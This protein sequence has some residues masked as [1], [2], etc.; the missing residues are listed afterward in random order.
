M[1]CRA[2]LTLNG[3]PSSL[4]CPRSAR[5]CVKAWAHELSRVTDGAPTQGCVGA[6]SR[7]GSSRRIG[8]LLSCVASHSAGVRSREVR[9]SSSRSESTETYGCQH[10]LELGA[11]P[12]N[13]DGFVRFP[14]TN[15]V[16]SGGYVGVAE[17]RR[18]GSFATDH[19]H[20]RPDGHGDESVRDYPWIIGKSTRKSRPRPRRS[21]SG[22]RECD[23]PRS[24]RGAA[25]VGHTRELA[26][27]KRV[28]RRRPAS[29][30]VHR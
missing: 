3:G 5:L 15:D 1:R 26:L 11:R 9:G 8:R 4:A 25:S 16:P 30:R 13:A 10:V 27:S 20:L 12:A 17:F 28:T 6:L 19:E 22:G 29:G 24:R 7:H 2:G 23:L 14:H 18:S 21:R